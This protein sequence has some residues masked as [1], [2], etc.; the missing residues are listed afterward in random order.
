MNNKQRILQSA[1]ELFNEKGSHKVS[2][3]HIGDHCGISPGNLYYHF[4]NKEAIIFEL[5]IQMIEEWEEDSHQLDKVLLTDEVL[6]IMLQKSGAFFWKYRFIHK[7]LIFLAEND[8]RL[9]EKNDQIQAVR[10]QQLNDLVDN[11]IKA[12]ILRQLTV[13]EKTFF[14][15]SLWMGSLFWQPYLEVTGQSNTPDNV[16]RIT[17]HFLTLFHLFR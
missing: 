16:E 14:V 6:M 4:K 9:R 8:P 15:D 7:E 3:N 2:T 5:F 17:H 13:D 1:L 11:N 10:M 12:K